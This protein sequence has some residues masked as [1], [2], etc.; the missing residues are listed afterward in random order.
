MRMGT[1]VKPIPAALMFLPGFGPDEDPLAMRSVPQETSLAVSSVPEA[2]TPAPRPTVVKLHRKVWPALTADD[3]AP[4]GLNEAR[5]IEL[6]LAALRAAKLGLGTRQDM[7]RYTGWGAIP[8]LFDDQKHEAARSELKSLLGEEGYEAAKASVTTAFFTPLEVCKAVWH[9]IA[10]A[11]FAGGRILEPSAGVGNLIGTMPKE[12]A[13]ASTVV[14]IEKDSA[15]ADLLNSLYG[16]DG[17]KVHAKGFEAVK[18]PAGSFDLVVSNVPFGDFGVPETRNTDYRNFLISDYFF[19]KALE[20]V[21]P[22]GLV[23][24]LTSHGT[25]D[26][27]TDT[28]RRWMAMHADLVGAVRLPTEAFK[29]YAGTEACVD[30][31]ILKKK[32]AVSASNPLWLRVEGM[33]ASS[34]YHSRAMANRA[35]LEGGLGRVVGKLVDTSS[36][37]GR[38]AL[39]KSED[40]KRDL[41][42]ATASY[43]V[44]ACYTPLAV[45]SKPEAVRVAIAPHKPGCYLVID[46]QLVMSLGHEAEAVDLGK[47]AEARVR[48]MLPLRE[49]VRSLVRAQVEIDA[50]GPLEA[51]RVQLHAQYDAFARAFGA[52][53]E[54]KNVAAL[55]AD[56]D[57]PLLMALESIDESGVVKK[58]DLF[59]RRT[60]RATSIAMST[61]TLTD[62]VQINLAESGGIQPR[63]LA[64]L[65]DW[66][67]EEVTT[68]LVEEGLAFQ[69]PQTH[70]WVPAFAYLSGDVKTKLA[71]AES[72]GQGFEAN[73]TALQA[74]IPADIPACDIVV[75]LGANWVPA[76]VYAAFCKEILGVPKYPRYAKAAGLWTVDCNYPRGNASFGTQRI[77]P[78]DLFRLALNQKEPEIKD[79]GHDGKCVVNVPETL[80]AKE[81]QQSIRDAFAKWI[82]AEDSRKAVLVAAYNDVMNRTVE[83]TWDG[84]LLTLPGFSD[85]VVLHKH[86]R[87]AIWR[88]VVSGR[89]TLLAHCVGAGKTLSMICA[90]MEMRRTGK[91]RKPIYVVP[92]HML[93]QFAMEFMRAYPGAS[94]LVASKDD[95]AKERRRQLTAKIALWDW[96]AV[97][98]THSSFEKV[99]ASADRIK[100]FIADNLALVEAAAAAT[101]DSASRKELEGM[102]ESLKSKLLK[103][104]SSE[105]KDDLLEF[106]ELGVDA[107]FLDESHLFKNLWRYTRMTRIAGLPIT[108]S[109][110]AFDMLMKVRELGALRGDRQGIVFATGTPVA[111]SV[112]ELWVQQNYLQPDDLAASGF[113]LFDAWAANFGE[114]VTGIELRPDG[115][116]YRVNTRFARF[117]NMPELMGLFRQIADIKTKDM[118]DLPTPEVVRETVTAKASPSLKAFVEHLVK[119]V[120]DIQCGKVKPNEDNMLAVTSDGRKA[121]T[122]MRLV[123]GV[124]EAGS[125]INLCV[126]KLHEIWTATADKRGAQIVFLDLSTPGPDKHWSLYDDIRDK[127]MARGVPEAEIA[128]IH[129]ANTDK[130][131]EALFEKVR[132]GAVRILLGSTSKMGVGTNVQKRLVAL[133]HLDAPWRPADVEQ[134]EGRIERQG[135]LNA[136]VRIIRY[137]TE[138]SF[139]GYMWQTLETKA[140]FIAQVMSGGNLRTVEDLEMA[141]LSYAEVK[142]LASGNPLVIEKAGVDAE[143]N[144]LSL[145]RRQWMDQN[146]SIRFS[147]RTLP[148]SIESAKRRLE[149]TKADI[150]LLEDV[151][152]SA[153][154]IELGGRVVTDRK[155]AAAKLML[156][157]YEANPHRGVV[158]LGKYAGLTLTLKA[159]GWA[160]PELR[161][162]GSGTYATERKLKPD[163][164]LGELLELTHDIRGSVFRTERH[165]AKLERE[166]AE[167]QAFLS[168]AG[169]E[170]EDRYEQLLTRQAEIDA[171]LGIGQ[172]ANVA[173]ENDLAEAA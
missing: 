52:L 67:I 81:K 154:R 27:V 48:A 147:A 12:I 85:C 162:E 79:R 36:R 61:S 156:A 68:G 2:I 51:L 70:A 69:C 43:T 72:A 7:T 101:D 152:G 112:A 151:A 58:A 38:A 118:L 144:R 15:S 82:W 153:F 165:I 26:K 97:V 4:E 109:Q 23:A 40:W 93:E 13:E 100:A 33:S 65:L 114:A 71:A 60:A 106:K 139:D 159:N 42:E 104:T 122:D 66:S 9:W 24:F 105:R 132:A 59:Y 127:L 170:H 140:K 111:N 123:G 102:K 136:S 135:N 64:G 92:N 103:L 157:V 21:R 62:A 19:G 88:M 98:M 148:G 63:R 131:K 158:T 32:A 126:D 10:Q 124:D 11:G 96:D 166:L 34:Y 83:T 41:A 108:D 89:N 120:D 1:R 29:G 160:G 146:S 121:A 163:T 150:E 167:A 16:N 57:F 5:R 56:A 130:A 84:S 115:G 50:E 142:A 138:G 128:F 44:A 91:A 35:F 113:S 6:N 143:V 107:L 173:F 119:R 164:V 80:A 8:K 155:E 169:W 53:R 117:I 87:D 141:A 25:L 14:A 168:G 47:D 22:G 161:L 28:A 125:K 37:F 77:A 90:G 99:T 49:T 171:Q 74:V 134:R 75:R 116:G 137:V 76:D 129:D 54:K 46:G 73:V 149:A 95:L 110:R 94:V 145:L 133:H 20:V 31:V 18:L 78:I 172:S 45:E 3:L 39:A 86:Q 30:L 55:K 17:V